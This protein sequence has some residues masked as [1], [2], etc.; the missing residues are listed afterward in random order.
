MQKVLNRSIKLHFKSRAIMWWQNDVY[1]AFPKF[2]DYN[3]KHFSCIFSFVLLIQQ[4]VALCGLTDI[5]RCTRNIFFYIFALVVSSIFTIVKSLN[6]WVSYL[7]CSVTCQSLGGT[8]ESNKSSAF[9]VEISVAMEEKQS[10]TD[11]N[12]APGTI[13]NWLV[14]FH[15]ALGE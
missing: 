7:T 13:Q 11:T 9:T 5:K 3:I 6:V 4:T 8:R 14:T 12:F 1:I 10:S 2:L 15:S